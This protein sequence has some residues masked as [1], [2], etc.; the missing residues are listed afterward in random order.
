MNDS[1][2]TSILDGDKPAP[3]A[4]PLPESTAT[5]VKNA[6]NKFSANLKHGLLNRLL[7]WGAA[8]SREPLCDLCH[9]TI[10]REQFPVSAATI[11]HGSRFDGD[12]TWRISH[13]DCE[14]NVQNNSGLSCAEYWIALD[15]L[16]TP[17]GALKMTVHLMGHIGF[18]R[19]QQDVI[20]RLYPVKNYDERLAARAS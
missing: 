5:T 20:A 14:L 3:L 6:I 18:P 12:P 13:N 7:F 1:N 4:E 16:S 8:E 19:W 15:R 2:A 17:Q 11:N 10:T 9:K